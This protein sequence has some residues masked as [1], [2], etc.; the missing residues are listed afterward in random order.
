MGKGFHTSLS[1]HRL[2][3]SSYLP[4]TVCFREQRSGKMHK[5]C[6]NCHHLFSSSASSRDWNLEPDIIC[7]NFWDADRNL[8]PYS[9]NIKQTVELR[10][11]HCSHI[12]RLQ[13][14]CLRAHNT[15][16]I[17]TLHL[18]PATRC[19]VDAIYTLDRRMR[20]EP[21][22]YTKTRHPIYDRQ[23]RCNYPSD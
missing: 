1:S 20:V 9:A 12:L 10:H 14:S 18:W 3:T 13:R 19:Q 16:I 23:V 17:C 15:I 5:I 11:W 7:P 2:T 8:P 22:V 6:H 4:I 21:F